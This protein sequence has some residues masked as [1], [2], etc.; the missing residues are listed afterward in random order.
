M[1]AVLVAVLVLL[2]LGLVFGILL[3]YS[4]IRFKVEGNPLVDQV[5]SLLP[6]TQCGQC[7]H[8]G[9]R[10]Y[11][12]AIVNGEAINKCPPGGQSTVEALADLLDVEVLPLDAE[13]AEE[14]IKKVA[15]IRE[16]EC[17]GCTKCIQACPVDAILGAAKQMH[18]VIVSECTGCDLCVEPCPVD[19]IDMLPLETTLNNWQWP[20]PKPGIELIATDRQPGIALEVKG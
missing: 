5:D 4:S 3:G 9:C 12:E 7:G 8:P 18:T 1:S 2:G 13:N 15:Y 14:P 20:A 10:P 19:C 11:A 17:I 6:Q 16:D